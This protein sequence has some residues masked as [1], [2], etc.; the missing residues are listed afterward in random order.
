MKKNKLKNILRAGIISLLFV[1]GNPSNQIKAQDNYTSKYNTIGHEAIRI[2][3]EIDS[4]GFT[5]R[6]LDNYLDKVDKHVEFKN[7][8]SEK[9]AKNTIRKLD[10]LCDFDENEKVDNPCYRENCFYLSVKE[11]AEQ[12]GKKFPIY[13][14]G[15][16]FDGSGQGDFGRHLSLRWDPDGKHNHFDLDNPVNKGSFNYDGIIDLFHY[17]K[18]LL[19]TLKELKTPMTKKSIE[20]GAYLD[21]LNR[22]EFLSIAHINKALPIIESY[23]KEKYEEA[24][25]ECEK[26]IKLDS[27]SVLNYEAISKL[28]SQMDSYRPSYT[29]K[30]IHYIN[31]AIDLNERGW[32]Y[33][34][35]AGLYRD[36]G[37][38]KKYQEDKSKGFDMI[39][40][41]H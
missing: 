14:F 31:K 20:K 9:E 37:D 36:L 30:A 27:N 24:L 16:V 5:Y 40:E 29:K 25:E 19:E 23:N 3:G 32:F 6:N 1:F 28:Y 10:S 11:L 22:E 41:E 21:N 17:D 33:I 4:I 12:K 34:K 13:A 39:M 18:G 8:Y 7:K 26:A 2:E 15:M 38:E 35:R